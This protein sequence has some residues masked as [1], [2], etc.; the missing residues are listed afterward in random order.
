MKRSHH[1]AN[2]TQRRQPTPGPFHH[3]HHHTFPH[4]QHIK[5]QPPRTTPPRRQRPT[6]RREKKTTTTGRKKNDH[7]GS[8]LRKTRRTHEGRPGEDQASTARAQAGRTRYARF[9]Y[10]FISYFTNPL[11]THILQNTRNTP[12]WACFPSLPHPLEH[13]EHARNGAFLVFGILP[14]HHHLPPSSHSHRTPRTRPKRRVFVFA[15]SL[16]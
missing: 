16:S 11:P 4:L 13:Q 6:Q 10:Y 1:D 8:K 9:F 5:T 7:N 3:H 14:L 12:V 2:A 15:G